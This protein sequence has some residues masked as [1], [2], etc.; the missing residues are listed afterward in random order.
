M[1]KETLTFVGTKIEKTKCYHYKC[2]VPL[3]DVT[4]EK[5]LVSN[6][7]SFSKK[8]YKCFIGYLCNYYKVKPLHIMFTRTSTYVKS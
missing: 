6:N 5:V 2:P 4:T 8:N 3:R 7:V 1:G